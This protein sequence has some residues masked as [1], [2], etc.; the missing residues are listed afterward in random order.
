MS[1]DV[2]IGTYGDRSKWEPL[3]KRAIDSAS[4]QARTNWYH[5]ETLAKARNWGASESPNKWLIFLDADDELS[6]G[7]VDAMVEVAEA[8][9]CDIFKPSTLGVVNGK[10]DDEAVMIPRRDLLRA[11]HIVIGAMVRRELFDASGGFRELPALEDWDLWLRLALEFDAQITEVPD[12]V[13][14]VHVQ[15]NS[16]NQ[17]VKAHREAYIDIQRRAQMIART[18]G[19]SEL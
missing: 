1:V 5:S 16:R 9:D 3:A 17:N 4:D 2:I 8:T 14:R 18:R 15:P 19:I 6:P 11:N 12:A 7:Y 13:Y 10:E